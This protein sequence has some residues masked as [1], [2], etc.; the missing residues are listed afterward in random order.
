[1]L[2]VL[3]DRCDEGI[4][5]GK[6]ENEGLSAV[7]QGQAHTTDALGKTTESQFMSSSRVGLSAA[8]GGTA[9]SPY[10]LRRTEDVSLIGSSLSSAEG[11]DVVVVW[12]EE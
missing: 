1:M 2:L 7:A 9:S 4:G 12:R 6:E 11:A 10:R 8:I 5:G 3:S